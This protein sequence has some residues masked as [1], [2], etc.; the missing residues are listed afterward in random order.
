LQ[1]T[2]TDDLVADVRAALQGVIDPELGDSIVDLGMVRS[3]TVDDGSVTVEIA[4]TIAGCPLRNQIRSDVERRV[5]GLPGISFVQVTTGA[6]SAEERAAVMSRAR[7]KAQDRSAV[8]TDFPPTARVLAVASGKGGVGKSSVTVNVAV[9]LASRGCTVGVLDA[10]VWGHSVPRLLGMDGELEARDK[11]MVP[12]SLAVGE[13]V[14]RVVSMGFLSGEDTAIMWR[15]LVLNRAVQHFLE[16]VRWGDLD[17]LLV[18]LP[19]GTG[20][21]QMGLARMLPRTEVL[22]VTTPPIA[23]QKVAGRAADMARK[24]HLR[25]AGVIENMS[26]FICAH[27][28]SYPLFGAGGGR[29]LADEIGVPLVGEV[30]LDP[31]VSAGGDEG[32]PVAL[33]G[34]AAGEAFRAIADRILTDVAPRVEMSGCSARMLDRVEQALGAVGPS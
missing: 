24:G 33:T 14:V 19:P 18:D 28:E 29:R 31:A 10:D 11:K 5:T 25:I 30:P 26:A 21:V 15:G 34:G 27:G 8:T 23:A 13:G 4:L 3:I 20:D 2:G 22:L 9:A 16:D 32:R 6:M 1:V 7:L 17:Y 12:L